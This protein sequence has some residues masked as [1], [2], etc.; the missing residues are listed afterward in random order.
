LNDGD[1]E[2]IVF[3]NR[4]IGDMA[5]SE[6]IP[7]LNI[8]DEG[9]GNRMIAW[10]NGHRHQQVSQPYYFAKTGKETLSWASVAVDRSVNERAIESAK[11]SGYLK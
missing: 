5:D 6:E 8:C 10:R 9:Y 2:N 3:F 4:I 11:K 7:F 1:A